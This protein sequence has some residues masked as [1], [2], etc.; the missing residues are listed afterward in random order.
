MNILVI[1]IGGT[2]VKILASGQTERRKFPSGPAMTPTLMVEGV[3]SAAQGWTYDR[4]SIGY[5][6]PVVQ[7]KP[8]AEPKN[9]APGWVGFDFEAAFGHPVKLINDAA[10]QAIGSYEGGRMLFLGLGTG[11]GTTMIVDGH[12]EPMELGHLP[13]RKRTYEDYVGERGLLR[14]GQ[15]KWEQRV[16]DVV[17]LLS[18]ALAA[19]LYRPGGRQRQAARAASAQVPRR[20]QCQRIPRAAFGCGKNRANN[21]A[22]LRDH[23]RDRRAPN[24]EG[25]QNRPV[26]YDWKGNIMPQKQGVLPLTQR[27]AWQAL[28]AHYQQVRNLHLRQLFA[29]DPERGQRYTLEA[30]GIYLDYSKNRFTRRDARIADPACRAVGP[31]PSASAPCSAARRSTS[32]SAGPCCTWRCGRRG[33][34]R[35]WST[36]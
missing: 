9:L 12:V 25:G 17:A 21:A 10:M 16:A 1:D 30:L 35:S 20:R 33:A 2:S 29:D 14:L 18:T 13:Y 15:K 23:K 6:G 36:A 32:P 28:D 24:S 11:L 27:P 22:I 7:G 8:V 26:R 19:G 5:P 31:A 3:K 34:S 4:I